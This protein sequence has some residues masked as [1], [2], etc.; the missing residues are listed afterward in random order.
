MLKEEVALFTGRG[1]CHYVYRHGH[2]QTEDLTE[3]SPHFITAQSELTTLAV[4]YPRTLRL[5]HFKIHFNI[6][7]LKE[8]MSIFYSL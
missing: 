6:I 4:K 5:A 2:V 8:M 3:E 7:L 1:T